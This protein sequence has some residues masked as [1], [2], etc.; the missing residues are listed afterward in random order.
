MDSG[1]LRTELTLPV[2]TP[3]A[4]GGAAEDHSPNP[5]AE[6]KSRRKSR[7]ETDGSEEA[8]ASGSTEPETNDT[9][10]HQVDRLA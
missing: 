2:L 6:R 1:D 9:E 8:L 3:A 4:S 5:N 10:P 7:F